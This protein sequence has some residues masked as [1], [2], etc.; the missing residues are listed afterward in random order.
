MYSPPVT[1]SHQTNSA[2]QQLFIQ[3]DR[4]SST[5]LRTQIEAALRS[6]ISTGR[7][8]LGDRLP[9][10][11]ELA[12]D[13]G[14]SRFVITEAYEQ[15]T[16][17]GYLSSRRGSGTRVNAVSAVR[18][19]QVRAEGNSDRLRYDFLPGSPEPAAFPRTAWLR[20]LHDAVRDTPSKALR[21]GDPAGNPSLRE[22][23]AG[24]LGRVRSVT[25]DPASIM[26]CAGAFH[27]FGLVCHALRLTGIDAIGVEDPSWHRLRTAARRAG[28]RVVPL[29]IDDDGLQV[30]ALSIH[31]DL[32]AVVVAPAHQ[33]PT[34][35][36]L[37][38]E[39]RHALL[40][41]AR[42]RDAL[43]IEDDYDAEF[44]YD[45]RPVGAVQG[46]DPERVAYVGSV[47][48]TLA[49]ALRLGWL[50]TPTRWTTRIRQARQGIDLGLSVFDQLALANMLESGA[51]DRHL[52]RTRT[53]Y[54][55]RRDALLMA[56][57]RHLPEA[58]VVGVAAGLHLVLLLPAGTD[59]SAVIKAAASRDLNVE[60]LAES[61][62]I[63]PPPTPGLVLGY[64]GVPESAMELA[65][66]RLAEAV[67]SVG[68]KKNATPA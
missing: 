21:Y 27:G 34:G 2:P 1:R 3:L 51:L 41:W 63:R 64:A 32:R 7:L 19:E 47:S 68:S 35:V 61:Y 67:A 42:R 9:A 46:L 14:C 37:S 58:Q 20:A 36:V 22:T 24:H 4:E 50:V 38:P 23:L 15:L 54:R 39:R 31:Q 18:T 8:T 59:E 26:V 25:A 11:R 12:K 43:V 55:A 33:F 5:P 56:L 60:G 57:K 45:R 49:P 10:S 29:P 6:A 48:K 53:T 62:A 40:D 28:L 17:A 13:L 30:N 52:R 65:I 66:S 16:A 44:R